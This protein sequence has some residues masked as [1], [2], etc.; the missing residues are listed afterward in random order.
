MPES[1]AVTTTAPDPT[2]ERRLRWLPVLAAA[3]LLSACATPQRPDPLEPINR[4]VY[5]FNDA[6]DQAVV[7]PVATIYRDHVPAPVRTA[8]TNFFANLQ[9]AWSSV[10]LLLQGR[11]VDSVSDLLR[12]GTNTVFGV[13]GLFDVATGLGL[14]RH[15]EDFGQTLGKW[16][17]GPGAYIVWPILGPSTLRD[18][19][20]LPIELKMYPDAWV[21]PN[22]A[23]YSLTGVRM[24][25][26]RANLLQASK[27]FNDIALDPYVAMRDAY[28]QRRRSLVYDGNPP[29]DA[30]PEERWD[31]PEAP[32]APPAGPASAPAAAA[33]APAVDGAASAAAPGASAPR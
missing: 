26:T 27:L 33:S 2:T 14:E 9:D 13:F 18:S 4:K 12:F 6:L 29:D 15:G 10:N 1:A 31:E 19:V 30:Q 5:A 3:L 8:A 20:G 7:R 32:A 23:S 16:G 24:V 28:L 11:P 22:S 21:T 25:N 17:L